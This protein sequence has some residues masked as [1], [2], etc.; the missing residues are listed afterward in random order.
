[1]TLRHIHDTPIPASGLALAHDGLQLKAIDPNGRVLR[2]RPERGTPVNY[3]APSAAVAATVAVVYPG[4]DNNL[5]FTAAVPGAD[6]N[7]IK[8][9]LLDPAE[10]SATRSVYID[11][12]GKVCVDLDTNAGDAGVAVI[13]T[14][15]EG[16]ITVTL[17]AAGAAAADAAER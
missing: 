16:T 15:E 8:V 6:A 1:M 10:D 13:P 5:T 9:A 14:V 17:E 7:G 12:D 11:N 2:V 3:V 4:Y